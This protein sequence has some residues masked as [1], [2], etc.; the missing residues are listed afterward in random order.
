MNTNKRQ[1]LFV[2]EI[3]AS[4][5]EEYVANELITSS[6]VTGANNWLYIAITECELS[7]S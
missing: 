1:I 7:R 4:T 6:K 2:G 5:E 3:E